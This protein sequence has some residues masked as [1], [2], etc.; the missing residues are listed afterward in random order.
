MSRNR[1]GWCMKSKNIVHP[2]KG[3]ISSIILLFWNWGLNFGSLLK[4]LSLAQLK[5][6]SENVREVK[7]R[8]SEWTRC[9]RVKIYIAWFTRHERVLHLG[10]QNFDQ[11]SPFFE[12]S[13]CGQKVE[14][15][16]REEEEE[17]GGG[18]GGGRR[19]RRNCESPWGPKNELPKMLSCYQKR[20]NPSKKKKSLLKIL[21]TRPQ[22]EYYWIARIFCLLRAFFCPARQAGLRQKHVWSH[23]S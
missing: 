14:T 19:R 10:D 2:A 6:G 16:T 4:L 20:E 17:E 7:K 18:G 11:K 1:I 13:S 22:Y 15:V 5:Y 12:I 8:G 3:L 21:S 9:S 23:S